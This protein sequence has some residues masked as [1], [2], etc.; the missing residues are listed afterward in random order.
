MP[1]TQKPPN[2]KSP[3]GA[4]RLTVVVASIVIFVCLVGLI[5]VRCYRPD[6]HVG[7]LI[8]LLTMLLMLSLM[9]LCQEDNTQEKGVRREHRRRLAIKREKANFEAQLRK[10][11][12]ETRIRSFTQNGEKL[13]DDVSESQMEFWE[14]N[15]EYSR[16][17]SRPIELIRYLLQRISKIV[18]N[19]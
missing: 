7:W 3:N 19:G 18:G 16:T 12:F 9:G 11:D 13:R 17:P 4:E 5:V 10:P 6:T 15:E 1:M 2:N 14:R 8:C